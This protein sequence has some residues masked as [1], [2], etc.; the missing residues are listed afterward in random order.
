MCLRNF[1]L[2]IF[3]KGKFRIS[4]QIS[5][6]FTSMDNELVAGEDMA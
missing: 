1:A 4:I 6:N 3:A 5:W 2:D